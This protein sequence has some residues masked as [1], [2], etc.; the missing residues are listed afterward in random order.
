MKIKLSKSQQALVEI[1]QNQ[2]LCLKHRNMTGIE[3]FYL[4][5]IKNGRH[6]DGFYLS[7]NT[8]KSLIKLGVLEVFERDRNYTTE[9]KISENYLKNQQNE[10]KI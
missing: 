10:P 8:V 5:N 4:E 9:Y 3:I 1:M 2:K 6:Y 7:T